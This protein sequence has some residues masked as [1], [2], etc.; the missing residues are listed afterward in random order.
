MSIKCSLYSVYLALKTESS[1]SGPLAPHSVPEK[2]VARLDNTCTVD[3]GLGTVDRHGKCW[4]PGIQ[5]PF[6]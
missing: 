2:F 5:D 4:D 3:S 1:L 6:K